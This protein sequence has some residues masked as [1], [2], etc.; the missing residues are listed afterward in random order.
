MVKVL[1]DWV[2]ASKVLYVCDMERVADFQLDTSQIS[3]V[4]GLLCKPDT[5]ISVMRSK[6][7]HVLLKYW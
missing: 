3:F 7:R 5:K 4:S 2:D 6:L 1:K